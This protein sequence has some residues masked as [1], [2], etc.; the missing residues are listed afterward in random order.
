MFMGQ[1]KQQTDRSYIMVTVSIPKHI[2]YVAYILIMHMCILK[3][4]HMK[5]YAKLLGYSVRQIFWMGANFQTN[6]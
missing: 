2:I 6:K 3:Q 5:Y 1:R 4:K